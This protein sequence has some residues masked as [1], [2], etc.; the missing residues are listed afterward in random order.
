MQG[1]GSPQVS[2][3]VMSSLRRSG[4]K[5]RCFHTIYQSGKCWHINIE[6]FECESVYI[7]YKCASTYATGTQRALHGSNGLYN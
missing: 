2:A 3:L 5:G 1:E 6:Y 4:S 7:L